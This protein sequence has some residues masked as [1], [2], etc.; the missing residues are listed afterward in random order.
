MPGS[1][2]R[3]AG[4]WTCTTWTTVTSGSARRTSAR[5][6]VDLGWKPYPALEAIRQAR[7]IADVLYAR[8]ALGHFHRAYDLEAETREEERDHVEAWQRGYPP[9]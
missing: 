2:S 6:E 9:P 4:P 7:P 3:A 8:D 5:A 1:S